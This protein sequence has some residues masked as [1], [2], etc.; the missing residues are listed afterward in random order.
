MGRWVDAKTS[1]GKPF[2]QWQ[3]TDEDE[4]APERD[5]YCIFCGAEPFWLTK[6]RDDGSVYQ[7][8]YIEHDPRLHRW[9][10]RSDD[11]DESRELVLRTP[12]RSFD[13]ED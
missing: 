5:D 2:K 11:D 9:K 13:D 6:S 1:T 8:C 4:R 12:Q 3:R 7:R 10:L